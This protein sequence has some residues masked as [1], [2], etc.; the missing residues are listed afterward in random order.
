[1]KN[2]LKACLV[3]SILIALYEVTW[4]AQNSL[5]YV[6]IAICVIMAILSKALIDIYSKK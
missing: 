5:S 4:I 2:L 3:V 1:M 6:L